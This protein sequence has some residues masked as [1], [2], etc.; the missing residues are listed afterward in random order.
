MSSNTVDRVQELGELPSPADVTRCGI[1]V[2]ASVGLIIRATVH[3]CVWT[4]LREQQGHDPRDVHPL[5][6]DCG[7]ESYDVVHGDEI[8]DAPPGNVTSVS[9]TVTA[10]VGLVLASGVA[11]TPMGAGP[12]LVALLGPSAAVMIADPL[13]GYLRWRLS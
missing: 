5:E 8:D 3:V 1:E 9:Q 13:V 4:A 11:M 12:E 6:T 7:L 10:G 2:W